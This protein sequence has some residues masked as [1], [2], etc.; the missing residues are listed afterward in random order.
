MPS[1]VLQTK[2]HS[3]S[4]LSQVEENLKPALDGLNIQLTF[5]EAGSRG[6]VGVSV[7]GEDE[8]VAMHYLEDNVG[9]CPTSVEDI[10]RFSVFKGYLMDPV[11][12]KNELKMDIGVSPHEVEVVISLQKLQAQLCDGRK[13]ALNKLIELF[14]LCKNLPLQVRIL[15]ADLSS[16]RVETEFTEGQQKLYADW[17]R[18]F[19]DRLLIIGASYNEVNAAL[20][21]A[22]VCRDI[23]DLYS[24]GMFEHAVTCKL[25]TDAAG[26]IPKVGRVLRKS[27]LGV[28]NSR[29][30]IG[31]L[32]EDAMLSS[33]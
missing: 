32:G 5:H 11:A 8:K 21:A 2:M 3:G 31:F 27:T 12:S 25:G 4:Q 17:T 29:R 28:F 19:L 6:W 18:S 33:F 24:F 7:S 16:R 23:V 9:F 15:Q 1:I 13:V 14:G 26:L 10:Q 22:G 20:Q 30:I